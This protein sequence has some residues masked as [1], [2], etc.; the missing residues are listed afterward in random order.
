MEKLPIYELVID[1][2]NESGVSAVALVDHPAIDKMFQAFSAAQEYKF[3]VQDEEKRM[4]SGPVM[5][6]DMPIYREDN[7]GRYYVT[8][9]AETISKIMQKY[10]KNNFQSS[11]NIMHE[12]KNFVDG[13]YM[14][15]SLQVDK[16]RG[17]FAPKQFGNIPDGSWFGTFK[18]DNDEVWNDFVKTGTVKGFSVEGIFKHVE[19]GEAP[20]QT[21][22]NLHD[23]ISKMRKTIAELKRNINP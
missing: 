3:K 12:E 1:E 13:V 14:I 19:I 22:E 2:N 18:V 9:K 15:E 17:M 21:L 5:L 4:I 20:S 6:A 23:R 7:N 10:F 8:F 11:V 16:K